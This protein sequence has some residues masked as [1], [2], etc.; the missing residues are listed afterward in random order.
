MLAIVLTTAVALAASACSDDDKDAQGLY[1]HP[2]EGTVLVKDDG[3]AIFSQEEGE[4]SDD[5]E[6]TYEVDGDRITFELNG[7]TVSASIGEQELVF[8][9][10]AYSGDEPV[11]FTRELDR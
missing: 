2:E 6:A 10:G 3:T 1:R 4:E 8:E 9:A 11:T 5:V 7:E